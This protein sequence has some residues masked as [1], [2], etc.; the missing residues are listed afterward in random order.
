MKKILL[1]RLRE[2][3]TRAGLV[4]LLALFGIGPEMG[5]AIG[6]LI[7]AGAAVAAIAIPDRG[8]E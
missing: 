4:V 6:E 8:A 7:A 5:T 2:P 3:S 1:A